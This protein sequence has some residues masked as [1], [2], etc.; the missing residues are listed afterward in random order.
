MLPMLDYNVVNPETTRY[1][2]T[3]NTAVA[4]TEEQLRNLYGAWKVILCNCGLE[5][6]NTVV[7]LVQ[8]R[9]VI[10]DDETYF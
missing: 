7:D 10:V 9:T 8:P 2:R 5:A 3:H 1:K 6:L 4:Q